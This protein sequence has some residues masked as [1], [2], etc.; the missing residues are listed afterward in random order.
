MSIEM[1]WNRYGKARV[2]VVKIVRLSD[3]HVIRDL[4]VRIAL[5]E[6]SPTRT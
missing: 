5:G 4:T 6:T 1:G 3:H 2:R